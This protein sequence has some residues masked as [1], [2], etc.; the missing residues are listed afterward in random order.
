MKKALE[1]TNRRRA[2]QI[3]FNKKHNITPST[4]IKPIREKLVEVKDIKHIPK[5]NIPTM[6]IELE[7]EM[8][9]AANALDFE[10]AITMRDR[11]QKLK[12]S[13]LK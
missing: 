2:L 5:K 6:I 11:I 1:E 7:T 9:K 10:R 12:Q 8:K 4:I 13:L 3:T